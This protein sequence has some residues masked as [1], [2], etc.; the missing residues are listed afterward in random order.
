M[1]L[2]WLAE[3]P[4]DLKLTVPEGQRT[5]EVLPRRCGDVLESFAEEGRGEG[6]QL[7]VGESVR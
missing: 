1:R 6:A 7:T 3:R 2:M 5:F 4:R